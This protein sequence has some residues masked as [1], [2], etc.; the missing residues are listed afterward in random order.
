MGSDMSE[1]F[2]SCEFVLHDGSHFP[3]Y[4]Q[5]YLN[6]IWVIWVRDMSESF[7]SCELVLHDGSHFSE[8]ISVFKCHQYTKRLHSTHQMDFATKWP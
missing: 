3:E 4:I 7:H 6:V 5:V 1:S 8:C 2:H